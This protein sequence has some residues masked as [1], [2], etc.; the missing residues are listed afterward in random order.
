MSTTTAE[1]LIRQIHA[2]NSQ[3]VIAITGGGSQAIGQL[4]SV[5]G[6]SRTLLEAIVPY[7]SQ[8]LEEFLHA[9]PEQFCSPRTARMMA[10][11]AFQRARHLQL[12]GSR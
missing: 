5:P 4:L 8:S 3:M 12:D 9:R 6:G 1:S 2:S 11:A 10:M 7:S